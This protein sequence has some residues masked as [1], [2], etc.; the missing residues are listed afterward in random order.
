VTIG[1]GVTS[2]GFEAFNECESLINVLI[3]NRVTQIGDWAFEDS[4]S[5]L[6]VVCLGNAPNADW[7]VFDGDNPVTIYYLPDT[8][9]WDVPFAGLTA[10]LWTAPVPPVPLTY[11]YI[12][13]S[14][15]TITITGCT[16]GGGDV[17]IWDIINGLTVTGI[18]NGAF[19]HNSSLTS[20]TIPAGI[21]NLG[22][23]AFADCTNLTGIY[24]LGNAPSPDVTV[25][26][27]DNRATIYYPPGATG[28]SSPFDGLLA[29]VQN[30]VAPAGDFTYTTINGAIIITGYTGAGGAIGIPRTIAGLPVVGIGDGAFEDSSL[31]S[32]TIPSSVTN[33]GNYA[34]DYCYNLTSIMLGNNVTSLGYDEFY[35]CSGLT[36]VTIG[37]N[38]A[39]IGNNAFYD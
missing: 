5:P 20:I 17:T 27:G 36:N 26:A 19:Q 7:T 2:I 30:P 6:T 28:W 10:V 23:A 16:G 24:F 25:F 38:V 9:G 31:T 29:E 22:S 8:T 21:T 11:T 13:N 15:N 35:G 14:D 37:N 39:N 33:I 34:F 1:N 4:G 3:G 32:V 12:T 18:A